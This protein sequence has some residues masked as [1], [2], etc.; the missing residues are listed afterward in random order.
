MHKPDT[1]NC[2]ACSCCHVSHCCH[3]GNNGCCCLPAAAC[4]PACL[5]ATAAAVSLAA[6]MLL[7]SASCRLLSACLP[8]NCCCCRLLLP[9]CH[10]LPKLLV[11]LRCSPSR[12]NY[13]GLTCLP[14]CLPL[15]SSHAFWLLPL[16]GT[17]PHTPP[18]TATGCPRPA[19]LTACNCCSVMPC[20]ACHWQVWPLTR[21]LRGAAPD[22]E[23][24]QHQ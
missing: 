9:P 18:V 14:A 22:L 13:R 15:L 23:Q 11:P 16:A 3:H 2:H 20:H 10:M 17:V 21:Q 6:S 1:A 7:L 8:A 19:C 12:G 5:L 24:Q 4:L